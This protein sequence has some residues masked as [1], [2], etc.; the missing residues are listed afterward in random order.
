[1]DLTGVVFLRMI[2]FMSNFYG[3]YKYGITQS[4][5]SFFEKKL[6]FF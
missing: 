4:K 3:I 6:G 2:F 1:M 5:G